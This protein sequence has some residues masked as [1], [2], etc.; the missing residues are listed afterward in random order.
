MIKRIVVFKKG[1]KMEIT[2]NKTT[3]RVAS[4]NIYVSGL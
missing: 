4:K 1:D 2:A 3:L